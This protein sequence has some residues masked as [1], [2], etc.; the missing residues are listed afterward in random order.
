MMKLKDYIKALSRNPYDLELKEKFH[1][2]CYELYDS[3]NGDVRK[4]VEIGHEEGA[5]YNT[6]IRNAR[7]YYKMNIEVLENAKTWEEKYIVPKFENFR[8]SPVNLLYFKLMNEEEPEKIIELIENSGLY[9]N[10]FKQYVFDFVIVY[11]PEQKDYLID[12]IRRKIDI[13]TEYKKDNKQK[14]KEEEKRINDAKESEYN[15]SFYLI[16]KDIL[17]NF[18]IGDYESKKQYCY[19]NNIDI[20]TFDEIVRLAEIFDSAKYKQYKEIIFDNSKKRFGIIISSIKKM[21]DYLKNG[22]KDE[23]NV[24]RDFDIIDYYLLIR[25]DF[26]VILTAAKEINLSANDFRLLRTFMAKNKNN[27]KDRSNDVHQI[28]NPNNKQMI[29][30][31]VIELEEK[32]FI[33]NFLKKNKIPKNSGTYNIAMRRYLK[34]NLPIDEEQKKL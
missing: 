12:D 32:E 11:Y 23:N 1:R 14:I 22:I 4:I 19:M 2:R 13:Y 31:R 3:V 18:I 27:I 10:Y 34:N 6:I 9:T 28:L 16:N 15:K 33:L 30:G 25:L 20:K 29:G 7:K 21:V 5:S 8:G 17:E 24:V 26:D